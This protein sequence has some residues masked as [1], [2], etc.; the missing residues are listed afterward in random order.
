LPAAIGE[1]DK[2]PVSKKLIRESN[3]SEQWSRPT[4]AILPQSVARVQEAR[5]S[6]PADE[7]MFTISKD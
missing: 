7:H 5:G 1:P 3:I 4:A 2:Q 6:S